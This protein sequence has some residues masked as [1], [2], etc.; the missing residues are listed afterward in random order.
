MPFSPLRESS[1]L[2]CRSLQPERNLP[3]NR[4][5]STLTGRKNLPLEGFHRPSGGN[6][7]CGD[8]HVDVGMEAHVAAPGMEDGHEP[9][10][11]PKV[12]GGLW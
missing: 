5:E 8:D 12:L 7:P 6:A 4:L 9:H 11:R 2:S 10:R 1:P 3:L